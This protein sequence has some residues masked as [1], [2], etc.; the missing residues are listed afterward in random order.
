VDAPAVLGENAHMCGM[1]TPTQR[2][3]GLF[4]VALV[5]AGALL[6]ALPAH[7]RDKESREA[8]GDLEQ[9][10]R[11]RDAEKFLGALA[12]V[13][14]AGDARAIRTAV[15]AYARL[16]SDLSAKTETWSD[17]YRLHGRAAAAFKDLAGKAAL[18]EI[19]R[20][21]RNR[22][23]D[24]RGRVLLLDAAAFNPRLDIEASALLA[25]EDKAPQVVRRSLRYL[26]NAKKVPVVEKIVARF[27]ELEAKHGK[28]KDAEWSRT[29]LTFQAALTQMLKVDLP[30][31]VDWRNYVEA[32]KGDEDF[33]RTN[34]HQGGGNTAITLFGAAVTGKN[35]AFVLDISGS[36]LT[37][38][39]LPA[40]SGEGDRRGRTVVGDPAESGG[41]KPRVPPQERRRITRA[42]RELVRVVKALPSDVRFN[43]IT[44]SSE[45]YPW[46]KALV[47]A[48]GENKEEAAKHIE[49]L[50]AEGITV[51]DMAIEEAFA[52]LDVDTIYL[53]TDGAPT[54]IG[55][56]G[57]GL[58]EDAE[59]IIREIHA[60]VAELNFLRE[61]R[62]FTLGFPDAKE[63]F[64]QK[65]S[66]DHGGRYVAIE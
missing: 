58:P 45:V 47:P 38:D 55:T 29:L 13:L 2:R 44:Y 5:L 17:F 54:H 15:E 9:A 6:P 40:K 31:A 66:A 62:I 20:L 4:P 11:D 14:A 32:H 21:L 57:P 1:A 25:L 26:R 3:A 53:I 10:V 27:A 61:V 49:E 7:S 63:D 24:W 59:R 46:K 23:G 51:T 64:L 48:S 41:G 60:R 43:L 39:P 19:D 34:G 33:F 8:A 56:A 28:S 65:L 30:S 52:D 37:T 16:A 22:K 36:M 12:G 35:I 42:K 18:D 50:R